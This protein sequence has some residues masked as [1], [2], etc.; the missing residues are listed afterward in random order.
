MRAVERFFNENERKLKT[1]KEL[2]DA[3]NKHTFVYTESTEVANTLAEALT[4]RAAPYHG[5]LVSQYFIGDRLTKYTKAG[6]E[7]ARAKGLKVKAKSA[8]K[9]RDEALEKFKGHSL[10]VLCSASRIAPDSEL[11]IVLSCSANALGLLQSMNETR[12]VIALFLG[13]ARY[14]TYEHRWL[15]AC[16]EQGVKAPI[17][18]ES[19]KELRAELDNLCISTQRRR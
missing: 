8:K 16:S 2:I 12:P 5:K 4:G 10:Q 19:V 1:A 14:K 3:L 7:F 11:G 6:V 13:T 18:V 15:K 9:Q 17:F